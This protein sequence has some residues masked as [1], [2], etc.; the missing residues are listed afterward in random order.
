MHSLILIIYVNNKLKGKS[1]GLFHCFEMIVSGKIVSKISQMNDTSMP[2]SYKLIRLSLLLERII[3]HFCW[4]LKKIV[5]ITQTSLGRVAAAVFF[6][7]L[8]S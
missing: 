7:L 8:N 1:N 4:R 5:L 2:R 3:F 6:F